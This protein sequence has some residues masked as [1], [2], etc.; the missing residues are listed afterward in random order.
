MASTGGRRVNAVWV[1]T[2]TRYLGQRMPS[3]LIDRLTANR[4][5]PVEVLCADCEISEVGVDSGRH[6]TAGDLVVP[7][8]RHS[9]ALSLLRRA[10]ID[11]AATCNSYAAVAAVR[12]KPHAALMLA[13]QGLPTP[14]TFLATDPAALATLSDEAWPLLLKPALGDNAHGI[15]RVDGPSDLDAVDWPDGLV[16]AQQYVDVTGVDLKLY[17]AGDHVWAVRRLSPLADGWDDPQPI[18]VT[19]ELRELAIACRET[20]GLCLYGVDVLPSTSG[21]LVVDVN[22]FPNYT[23]IPDAVDA[24]AELVTN[25]ATAHGGTRSAAEEARRR[26]E[27]ATT[28]R[29]LRLT[30]HHSG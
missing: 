7:R 2:D 9:F 1:I 3:A 19:G 15:V 8:T 16:L 28:G 6:P 14:R 11:G 27:A 4:Q 25:C 10:E 23:G 12:D 5:L 17:G 26:V 30:E 21:P 13:G 22:D 24:V 20:F 18:Q 29:A